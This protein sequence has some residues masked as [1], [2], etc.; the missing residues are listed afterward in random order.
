VLLAERLEPGGQVH[1]VA[2]DGVA[3]AA[4]AADIA[5][6]QGSGIDPD[7]HPDALPGELALRDARQ[8]RA[9]RLEGIARVSRGLDR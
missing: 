4:A 5:G 7:A 2:M 6:D 8:D 9:R 3:L 1:R